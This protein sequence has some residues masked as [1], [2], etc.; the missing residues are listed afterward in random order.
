MSSNSPRHCGIEK[1][2][3]EES[4][5]VIVNVGIVENVMKAS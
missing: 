1:E 4:G 2:P 5:G 3:E